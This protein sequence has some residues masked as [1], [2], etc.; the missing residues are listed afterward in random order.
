[1]GARGWSFAE[2]LPFFKRIECY[3]EGD[4][5]LRGRSGPIGVTRM[6]IE[7]MHPISRAWIEACRQRGDRFCEDV[8]GGDPLGVAQMQGNWARGVR[9]SAA[10]AYLRPAM[11]R[12]NLKVV[13]G[14]QATRILFEGA[15]AVGVEYAHNGERKA[16][17]A[18]KEV[19]LAG[20][21]VNSPQLLQLSGIGDPDDLRP[22]GVEV[23]HALPGVGRNLRDHISVSLKQALSAPISLLKTLKP[24]AVAKA[25]GA[26]LL[27]RGGPTSVSGLEA[28]SHLK[29]RPDLEYPDIQMYCVHLMYNDHGRDVIPIEGFMATLNGSR[30]RSMGAVCIASADPLAAPLIDPSYL[31][32]PEDLRVLRAGLRQAR[33]IIAQP[34][35]D[36]IRGAEFAP[37]APVVDDAEL[38]HYIRGT[39]VTLYHPVGTC[40]MGLD[41]MAVV[42]PDLKVRGVEALRVADASIM[43]D[44]TSGNTNFPVMAI[45][46]K[47]A[48]LILGQA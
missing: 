18:A 45:A 47:A 6:P 2:L 11:A 10:S 41:E 27:F 42:A 36:A 17:R 15:R 44:I 35:F 23:A 14:A 39:A 24:L 34:A 40:K 33:E 13:T 22:C 9:Q 20:G 29:S 8:N 30:P 3:P 12:P 38:D 5:A 21:V 26:Y 46:E 1:M 43:P 16:V 4:P 48:D 25:L 28:W 32:D 19:I 7:R 31:S 37:G